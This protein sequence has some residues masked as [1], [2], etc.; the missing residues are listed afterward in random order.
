MKR[1]RE[2]KN[3]SRSREIEFGGER[4]KEREKKEERI[5]SWNEIPD[6]DQKIVR[7]EGIK[8]LPLSTFLLP[9]S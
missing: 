9:Y 4:K 6:L 5:R 2:R 7:K 8:I 3:F 1:E